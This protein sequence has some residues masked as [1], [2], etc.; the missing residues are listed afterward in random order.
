MS[1]VHLVVIRRN[2]VQEQE[3]LKVQKKLQGNASS[4]AQVD[5][6]YSNNQ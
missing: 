1:K 5:K 6:R 4:Q 2:T 3:K